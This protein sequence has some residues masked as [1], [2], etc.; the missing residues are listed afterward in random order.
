MELLI[1]VIAG[2]LGTIIGG[3]VL[4]EFYLWVGP[5]SRWFVL[6]AARF[7]PKSERERYRAEWIADIETIPVSVARL[8]FALFLFVAALR[9]RVRSMSRRFALWRDA[10]ILLLGLRATF[11][12]LDL[13]RYWSRR[14]LTRIMRRLEV[15]AGKGTPTAELDE[16]RSLAR[17]LRNVGQF[18]LQ[19]GLLSWCEA[20]SDK[21]ANDYLVSPNS[22]ALVPF[23]AAREGLRRVRSKYEFAQAD[24]EGKFKE[25]MRALGDSPARVAKPRRWRGRR[26]R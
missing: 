16:A 17:S 13:R 8:G 6:Q 3:V 25:A 7:V 20:R 1:A 15:L 2:V 10:A 22:R 9:L 5:V 14:R 12:V 23:A 4:A 18:K 24:V 11:W 19:I 26:R 21:F